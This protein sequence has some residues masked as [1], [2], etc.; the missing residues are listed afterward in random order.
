MSGGG[1][2]SDTPTG[3]GGKATGGAT[4]SPTAN[5]TFP[6][7]MPGQ[8]EAIASQLGAGFGQQPADV[9]SYLNSMYKPVTANTTPSATTTKKPAAQSAEALSNA[10][11]ST[12]GYAP[13]V[14]FKGDKAYV[15]NPSSNGWVP[16]GDA[17]QMLR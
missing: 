11:K 14:M 2:L 17:A 1:K 3:S 13:Q 12:L 9:L 5:Q 16:Y 6:A 10:L 15:H 7:A 8:L 4:P